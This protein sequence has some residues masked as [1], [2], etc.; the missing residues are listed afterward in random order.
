MPLVV[1]VPLTTTLADLDD[2][3]RKL[4]KRELGRHGFENVDIAFDAPA[5][6]WSGKLTGPTVNLFL[7][8]VREAAQP[9]APMMTE[10]RENGR[11]TMT[12]PAL[13]LEVTYAITAWTKAIE[14]EHRLLSQI[15]S[16]LHSYNVFPL[17]VLDG[18]SKAIGP[19]DVQIGRPM[20]EKADFWTAVGGQYKPAIDYA[21]T[22]A[23]ASGA[24]M[25]RGPEVR[26][27]VM[28]TQMIDAPRGTMIEMSRFG[29]KLVDGDGLPVVDA[30]V[31]IPEL[32]AWTSSNSEG[33]F[34]FDR[35]KPGEYRVLVRS[36]DAGE[37]DVKVKV[38]GATADIV[39][40][41]GGKKAGAVAR[42]TGR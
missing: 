2:A 13:R 40:G 9:A 33:R 10:K 26:T 36:Q 42:R 22:I 38:P 3:L 27:Q 28:R 29:G 18:R 5:R 25:E 14:D 16:I 24:S 4:L 23:L 41:E 35:M 8:D 12:P 17:D 19:I 37:A 39:V 31:A 11:T 1:D 7:Y 15:L 21:I 30:W 34:I 32:G 20:D 6:E